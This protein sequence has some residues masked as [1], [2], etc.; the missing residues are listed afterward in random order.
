MLIMWIH[1]ILQLLAT[2]AGCY[3]LYL[4]F[5]RFMMLHM[6]RKMPF[7][8]K[9]HVYWGKIAIGIWMIGLALGLFFAWVGWGV[10]LITDWHYLIAFMVIP[11]G[12]C[13]FVTG[14]ILD[15]YKKRRKLLPLLHGLNNLLLMVLVFFQLY[16][17]ILIIR[18]YLL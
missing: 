4:G 2:V 11:T 8:W 17:G 18:D 3:V 5:H 10:I 13:A 12:I 1:P 16:T 7:D 15:K 6:N 9:K 14:Y